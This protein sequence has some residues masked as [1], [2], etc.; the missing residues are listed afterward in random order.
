MS[1]YISITEVSADVEDVIDNFIEVL[2]RLGI[3][4]WRDE[5]KA[6]ELEV[7]TFLNLERRTN[8]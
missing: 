8:E 3:E 5:Q 1:E 4:V 7:D 6:K 2:D